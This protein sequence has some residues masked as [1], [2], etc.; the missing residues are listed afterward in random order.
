MALL[1]QP[2]PHSQ[3]LRAR[4]QVDS[5]LFSFLLGENSR[6]NLSETLTTMVLIME[7]RQLYA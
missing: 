2:L 1:L 5:A 7:T 4:L 6:Q 3:Q